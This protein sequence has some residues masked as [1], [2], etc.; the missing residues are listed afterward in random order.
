MNPDVVKTY[1][2]T[3]ADYLSRFAGLLTIEPGAQV[4]LPEFPG[5]LSFEAGVLMK[6]KYY[7]L[8][9]KFWIFPV[10]VGCSN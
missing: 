8:L 6:V 1:R 10:L 9:A 5:D 2:E 7:F 3:A 4:G